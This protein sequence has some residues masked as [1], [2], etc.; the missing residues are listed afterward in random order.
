M[1]LPS[2]WAKDPGACTPIPTPY[3]TGT[4]YRCECGQLWIYDGLCPAEHRWQRVEP[5][6]WI[7]KRKARKV[8]AIK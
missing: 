4:F 3:P 6:H 7:R 2:R 8:G 1:P 5:W